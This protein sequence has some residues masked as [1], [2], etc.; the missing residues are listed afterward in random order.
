[1]T[2]MLAAQSVLR[3]GPGQTYA[4]IPP[5][6]AAAAPGD[7]VLVAAGTYSPF[8]LDKGI[9]LRA[10]PVGAAVDIGVINQTGA[11]VCAVPAGQH[12]HLE[13][14]SCLQ[15]VEVRPPQG[16]TTAGAVSF[17]DLDLLAT[18]TVQGAALALH[19]C[20]CRGYTVTGHGLVLGGAATVS[21]S[22]CTIF[23]GSTFFAAAPSGIAAS[24]TATLSC[25]DCTIEGGYQGSV[26]TIVA[27]ASGI[28]LTGAARVWLVDS[29]ANAL[30]APFVNAFAVG[31]DNQSSQ[32]VTIER[33]TVLDSRGNPNVWTGTVQ[34]GLL[35]G[36]S[37]TAPMVRGSTFRL[38]FRSRPGLPVAAHGAFGLGAPASLPLLVQPE[39]GF[40]ANSIPLALMIADAQGAAGLPVTLPNVAW[41]QDLPLWFCGWTEQ[42]LPLQLSPVVGGLVR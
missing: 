32:P 12:G 39:W 31:I 36:L 42:N 29:T 35:L 18:V 6:I 10:D 34:P 21:A 14:L 5:A 38:D 4:D 15:A 25:S 11:I 37:T 33:C 1:M 8:T 7:L 19:R 22:Q 3:V 20:V 30:Q 27:I 16:A 13:Q 28:A 40:A 24:G 17:V 2:T 41:L 9:T 26:H 23:G